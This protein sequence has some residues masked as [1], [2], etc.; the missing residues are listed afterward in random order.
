ME[1]VN[2]DIPNR[3]KIF[4]RYWFPLIVFATVIFILSSIPGDDFPPV[5]KHFKFIPDWILE[6]PDKVVHSIIYGIL[7]WLS[8]R[9]VSRTSPN[10]SLFTAAFA[11]IISSSY[12]ASDEI[13]QLFVSK[14]SCDI[15]DWVADSVG[16][17]V[18]IVFLYRI[19]IK[20]NGLKVS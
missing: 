10:P 15:W 8:L 13:H 18:V 17:L 4:I 6:H 5:P 3:N 20:S 11:F 9:A 19:Y 7:G 14:R 16:S 12:G 2:L 1:L